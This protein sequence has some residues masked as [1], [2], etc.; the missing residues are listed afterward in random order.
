MQTPALA[1]NALEATAPIEL[2]QIT[3]VSNI[4]AAGVRP[5]VRMSA[6]FIANVH[7][8][9]GETKS[10]LGVRGSQVR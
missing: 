6:L 5:K 10:S 7:D 2:A 8:G 9:S 4:S 3:F 1:L